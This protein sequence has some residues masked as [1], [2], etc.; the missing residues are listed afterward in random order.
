MYL[1]TSVAVALYAREADSEKYET[2]VAG[3]D[4]LFSSEL[5][6]GEMTGAL[7]AKEK[8][9]IISPGLRVAIWAKFEEHISDGT[10]QLVTL[11][12]LLVHEAA[13]VMRQVYPEILLRTLDAIHLATYLSVEAGP[14]FTRD[15]R[16]IAAM[17]K[18]G[19]P[20]AG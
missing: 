7:L 16:M 4:G 18:L 20:R 19:I 2:I 11:N 8:N 6:V 1:D 17:K 10:V 15:Q 12:G 13:E 3:S 9:K 5:L 14:L